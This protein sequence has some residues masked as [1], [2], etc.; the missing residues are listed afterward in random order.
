MYWIHGGGLTEGNGDSYPGEMLTSK[1][2]VLVT[3]NYRLGALGFFA[4]EELS[5]EDP[6]GVSGNQGIAD[7]IAGLRWVR[8][9]IA[10]F[11]GD[12]NSVT[13]FGESAGSHSVSLVHASPLAKGLFHRAIGQSGGAFL[14]MTHLTQ[15]RPYSESSEELGAQFAAA[16]LK[17]DDDGSG[18]GQLARLRELP[19]DQ[20]LAAQAA[21]PYDRMAIVDGHVIPKEVAQIFA[22]GEQSDVPLLTGSNANE[23]STFLPYFQ[24]L[25]GSGQQ[26]FTAYAAA[27]LP[28]SGDELKRAYPAGDD[29]EADISFG[30]LF[31]DV[32]FTYPQRAW[33]SGMKSVGSPAYL[34]FFTWKPPVE[35]TEKYGA[36]HAA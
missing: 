13:I 36:F 24:P 33:A 32:Y 15:P 8:D 6:H 10:K 9:N 29:S 25:F 30:H 31:A 21:I 5:A 19:A 4:H 27:T 17:S 11:G 35:G 16:L 28:E 14:P 34:Y 1:G 3:I 20:I 18:E 12:P 7:Q 26:G 2:V 22:D 23:G